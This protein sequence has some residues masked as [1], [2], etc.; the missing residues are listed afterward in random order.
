[1]SEH[2]VVQLQ[3]A[4]A[5]FAEFQRRLLV[6]GLRSSEQLKQIYREADEHKKKIARIKKAIKAA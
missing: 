6:G 1:M 3:E 5:A 2:L 4:E